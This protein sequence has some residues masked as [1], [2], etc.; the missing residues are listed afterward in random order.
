[1]LVKRYQKKEAEMS[2]TEIKTEIVTETGIVIETRIASVALGPGP[3][4][5]A[6]AGEY[7]VVMINM[8]NIWL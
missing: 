2:K 5:D 8:L 3:E 7:C 1:M 4:N 6:G